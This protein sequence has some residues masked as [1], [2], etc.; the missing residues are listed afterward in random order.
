MSKHAYHF[1][2]DF[3]AHNDEKILD[4][5]MSLGFEGYGIFW[6]LIEIL[7]SARNYKLETN[8]KRIA[9]SSNIQEKT[10]KMVIEDFDLFKIEDNYFYSPSLNERM[11]KLD[12]IK[13]KA[14]ENGRLGG[15]ASAK[16]RAERKQNSSDRLSSG[17]VVVKGSSSELNHSKEKKRKEKERI[18]FKP[19]T[20]K[21]VLDYCYI[22]KE[23]YSFDAWDFYDQNDA[24]DWMRSDGQQIKNWKKT[25]LTW[26]K[27]SYAKKI[28]RE[29][30][31]DEVQK[32][33]YEISD[34]DKVKSSKL[35][36]GFKPYVTK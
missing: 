27:Q 23:L 20:L 21:E 18:E 11:S 13:D 19:P 28:N 2:H 22:E 1:K 34:V 15:I 31:L 6:Y 30:N 26:S 16:A 9:F 17:E 14:K 32:Y 12:T 8:Y 25:L 35:F 5:R 36:K 7:A 10:L 3:N 29:N 24:G 4:L 33:V